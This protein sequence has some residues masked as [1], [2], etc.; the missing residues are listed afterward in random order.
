MPLMIKSSED[1]ITGG[2]F[3]EIGCVTHGSP[4]SSRHRPR[5]EMGVSKI[6][7]WGRLLSDAPEALNVPE[8]VI[9]AETLPTWTE[10]N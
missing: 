6:D 4:Q 5:T 9:P 10:E 7:L 2:L 1:T 3:E 8:N